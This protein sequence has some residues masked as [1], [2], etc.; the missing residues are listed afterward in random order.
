MNHII[1]MKKN[2][3]GSDGRI[4]RYCENLLLLKEEWE[5]EVKVIEDV[6]LK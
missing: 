1:D 4:C 2:F 6:K 5:L 3:L